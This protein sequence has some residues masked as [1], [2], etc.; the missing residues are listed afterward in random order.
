MSR[1]VFGI[2]AVAAGLLVANAAGA[3]HPPRMERCESHTF[4]GQIERI[5]WH[6]PH[7]D[8]Y[9]RTED[10]MS[11]RITWLNIAQLGLAGIDRE[12][13]HVGDHVVITA[14]T[15]DDVVEKPMLLSHIVRNS[16]GW[17]WSQVPQGC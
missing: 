10:G 8:L 6:N 12:T 16:D 15:R 5:Q 7:V 4:S 9:I 13:L 1:A 17:E 2:L 14:G 3:H 11:Q